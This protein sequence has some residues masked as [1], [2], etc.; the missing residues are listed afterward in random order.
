MLPPATPLPATKHSNISVFHTM[1]TIPYYCWLIVSDFLSVKQSLPLQ[2]NKSDW[3]NNDG[4]EE[5]RLNSIC[6]TIQLIKIFAALENQ[7]QTHLSPSDSSKRRCLQSLN[8]DILIATIAWKYAL[9]PALKHQ[10]L[11]P[12]DLDMVRLNGSQNKRYIRHANEVE[13]KTRRG[14]ED[15]AH[16]IHFH[17]HATCR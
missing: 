8:F 16:Q 12:D 4:I 11:R 14:H 3:F 7:S 15:Q 17:K 10:F 9:Q 1:H 2:G 13:R 6:A 5:Y